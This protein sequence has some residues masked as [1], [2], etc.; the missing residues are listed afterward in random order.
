MKD[1]YKVWLWFSV[2]AFLVVGYGV[3]REFIPLVSNACLLILSCL[4]F[5]FLMN[6]YYLKK[7]LT[8]ARYGKEVSQDAKIKK[9]AD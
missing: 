1:N 9:A 5:T 2:Y 3:T 4:T 7:K 8:N 6:Y